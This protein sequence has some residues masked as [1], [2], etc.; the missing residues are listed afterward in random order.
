MLEKLLTCS[1]ADAQ[2][3]SICPGAP[4]QLQII[5]EASLVPTDDLVQPCPLRAD[6]SPELQALI[7]GMLH[8]DPA[9][10]LAWQQVTSHPFWLQPLPCSSIPPQPELEGLIAQQAQQVRMPGRRCF[11]QLAID[12][13][14]CMPLPGGLPNAAAKKQAAV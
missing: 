2:A 6:A 1:C 9:R 13:L 5:S 14:L 11:R 8:K 4:S 3:A 12:C 7:D 10:R